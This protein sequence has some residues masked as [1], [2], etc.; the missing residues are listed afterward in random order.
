MV[1]V[2][3]TYTKLRSGDWGVRVT[4]DAP[5]PG[6][7]VTATTKA[8]KSEQH[9]IA[10]V[11]WSGDGVHICAIEASGRRSGSTYERGVGRTCD[12]CGE[13]IVRGST[14]WETGASH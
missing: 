8:G 9:V 2:T 12:E 5:A 4:G 6:V 14:C 11:I 13:K 7:V 3:A 10:R 1:M